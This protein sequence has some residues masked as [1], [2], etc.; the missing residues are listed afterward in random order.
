MNMDFSTVM[1]VLQTT[2]AQAQEQAAGIAG[3]DIRVACKLIASAVAIGVGMLGAGLG[4]GFAAG[5]ACEAISRAPE[6]SGVLTRTMLIGQAVTES[7]AIY[8]LVISL[9]ILFVRV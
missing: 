3:E 2:V 7:T 1:T 9:L 4:E 8:A 5:K 6:H